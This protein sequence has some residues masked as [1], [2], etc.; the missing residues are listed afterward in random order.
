MAITGDQTPQVDGASTP[1]GPSSKELMQADVLSR[2]KRVEG[3]VRGIQKMV[4]EQRDCSDIVTQ[5][6]AVKA[7]VAR[8]SLTVVHCHLA[9][10][11]A[12][13]LR[14]DRDLKDSLAEAMA[15]LKKLS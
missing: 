6:A 4:N 7:A 9:E 10:T 1:S 5:L 11:L 14:D 8:V 13:D 2:L 15:I 3:Q 12:A